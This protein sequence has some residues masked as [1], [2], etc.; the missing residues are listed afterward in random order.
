MTEFGRGTIVEYNG[1]EL[2]VGFRRYDKDF[3]G[4]IY[5]LFEL[6]DVDEKTPVRPV[7]EASLK[8]IRVKD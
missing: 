4:N 5:E 8:F 6:D 2:R 7:P 1:R 3:G